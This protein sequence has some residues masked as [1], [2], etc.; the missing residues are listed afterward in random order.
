C[1]AMRVEYELKY[2]Y[3][4]PPTV[5]DPAM[6]S[7]VREVGTAV[8]GA[9]NVVYPHDIVMWAEDMSYMLEQ[10]PGAYFIVGARGPELGT[11]P[12]HSANYDIDERALEVGFKMMVGLGL[13]P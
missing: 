1:E 6:N 5:N 7:L 2:H 3:G 4:Y 12:Q 10:R 13:Q 8:L 9:D 11:Y